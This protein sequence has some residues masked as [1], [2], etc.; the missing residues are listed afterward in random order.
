M[1]IPQGDC[2]NG[3]P[4]PIHQITVD[5]FAQLIVSSDL[6]VL[7]CLPL[8]VGARSTWACRTCGGIVQANNRGLR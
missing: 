6:A 5:A 7:S 3:I 2:M 8:L 4:N 1:G